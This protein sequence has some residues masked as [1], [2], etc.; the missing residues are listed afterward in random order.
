MIWQQRSTTALSKHSIHSFIVL[1]WWAIIVFIF[2]AGRVLSISFGISFAKDS[3]L[4][5]WAILDP[6]Y[7]TNN[8]WRSIYYLHS[9][10]PLF[11]LIIGLFLQVF[12]IEFFNPI[13]VFFGLLGLLG[14]LALCSLIRQMTGWPVVSLVVTCILIISPTMILYEAVLYYEYPVCWILVLGFW[15]LHR[16]L[17]ERRTAAGFW[18]FACF[19]A[20]VLMRA[21][22]HPVWLL[23]L[24]AIA[25]SLGRDRRKTAW[26]AALPVLMV[27]AVCLKNYVEFDVVGLSSWG[28][29][30]LAKMTADPLPLSLREQLVRDGRMAPE[31]LL[32][33]FP[34]P[35][36]LLE[37]KGPVSLTGVPELDDVREPCGKINFNHIIYTKVG[38]DYLKN[39]QAGLLTYPQGFIRR[40]GISL[41]YFNKPP[42]EYKGF[43]QNRDLITLWD[44][45]YDVVIE[46]QP[47]ALWGPPPPYDGSP[48]ATYRPTHPLLQVG[49]VDLT[50]FAL[51]CAAIA[52]ILVRT[53]RRRAEMRGGDRVFLACL[54]WTLLFAMVIVNS[55]DTWENNR[56]R[57]MLV[58]L[59]WA[60]ALWLASLRTAPERC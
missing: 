57:V 9:Q 8:L 52:K 44:R 40:L 24:S 17:V 20:V 19:A 53:V 26:A 45:I 28:P 42:T 51:T 39:A 6:A 15:A 41:Y 50:I 3:L 56:A 5:S 22:F 31:A 25:L 48:S 59:M 55:L 58:P 60:S 21:A 13:W 38:P 2:I 4:E 46:G 54:A 27:L 7:L 12:G 23:V 36:A 33:S 35:E 32:R 29:L 30:N 16:F 49:Y 10:P 34:R 1:N 18:A 14:A 47:A 11:N 43:E 37:I